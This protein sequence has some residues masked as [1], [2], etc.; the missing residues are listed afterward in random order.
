MKKFISV[1]ALGILSSCTHISN[2]SP[3]DEDRCVIYADLADER[4]LTSPSRGNPDI[5]Q[6]V[7]YEHGGPPVFSTENIN[8][9]TNI[10]NN[11]SLES[12]N[13]GEYIQVVDGEKTMWELSKSIPG[14]ALDV[15]YLNTSQIVFSTDGNYAI[16]ETGIICGWLCGVMFIHLFEF[17]E[18]EWTQIA[19]AS[20]GVV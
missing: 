18:G 12:C 2:Y 15:D 16:V 6:K 5:R 17:I 14:D 8:W 9:T 20:T 13:F 3:N 4:I 11:F 7:F 19:I 1:V 10:D